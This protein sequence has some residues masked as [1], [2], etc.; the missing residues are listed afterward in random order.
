[1]SAKSEQA[2]PA[3]LTIP[4]LL[5]VFLAVYSYL[6]FQPPLESARE[7]LSSLHHFSLPP[8]PDGQGVT[9]A[10]L[11]EDPLEAVHRAKYHPEGE[12]FHPSTPKRPPMAQSRSDLADG[13]KRAM[14]QRT[15]NQ[16]KVPE[17]TKTPPV[18]GASSTG[19]RRV[20]VVCMP[21]LLPGGPYAENSEQR[22]RINYA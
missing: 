10:R 19:S 8:T 20:K 3:R 5:V 18:G 2:S 12:A 16:A 1:M 11:W 15:L 4:S 7:R 17:G 14:D 9:W 6:N 21:V 22:R 13:L